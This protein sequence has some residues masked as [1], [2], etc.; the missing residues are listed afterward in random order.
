MNK[1]HPHSYTIISPF[2]AQ[3]LHQFNSTFTSLYPLWTNYP[4]ALSP[5]HYFPLFFI[6][7]LSPRSYII[8]PPLNKLPPP[9]THTPLYPLRQL[10]SFITVPIMKK[11]QPQYYT[12]IPPFAAQILHQFN[13]IF[14]SLYPLWR[15]YPLTLTPFS[16]FACSTL[17]SFYPL[18]QNYILTLTPF[19]T[20]GSSTLTSFHHLWTITTPNSYTTLSP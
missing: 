2:A 11:L 12:I 14:N 18:W 9:P 19:F 4:L 6:T 1:L 7:F 10:N 5:L 15:N 3:I 17:K 8:L 20:F 13:S 16:P